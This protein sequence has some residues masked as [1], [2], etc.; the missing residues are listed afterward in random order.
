MML[1]VDYNNFLGDIPFH[2]RL[3]VYTEYAEFTM[4]NDK[5]LFMYKTEL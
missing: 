4:H 5:F 3:Y 1:A 2:E